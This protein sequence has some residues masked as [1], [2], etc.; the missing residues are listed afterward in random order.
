MHAHTMI[1]AGLRG[2]MGLGQCVMHAV[3]DV[4]AWLLPRTL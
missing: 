2:P 3:A 1:A 4:H